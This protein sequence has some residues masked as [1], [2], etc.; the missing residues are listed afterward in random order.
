VGQEVVVVEHLLLIP[1]MA[2]QELRDKVMLAVIQIL[3][4]THFR[5]RVE[6]AQVRLEIHHQM[7]INQVLA[8]LDYS[9]Q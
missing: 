3:V 7:Q 9:I 8:V 4:V 2:V 6:V 1:I 5:V